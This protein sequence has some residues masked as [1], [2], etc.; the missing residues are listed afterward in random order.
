MS[1]SN[2][3]TIAL[4]VALILVLISAHLCG[5]L[6]VR[7][8]QPR[9]AG[10]IVGGLILGPTLLGLLL[11]STQRAIF[12]DSAATSWMLGAIYQLGLFLLMFCSGAALRSSTRPGERRATA[13]I[14][15]IGNVIPFAA[16]LLFIRLI[17]TGGLI[18]PANNST[19][20]I[21]IFACGLA[22]TSI[23]VI[24]KIMADLGILATSFARIV[25]AVAVIEDVVL[26]VIVSV[27]LGLVAPAHGDSFTLPSLLSIHPSTVLG[28]VYYV[29][30]SIVFFALPLLL[31][32]KFL[33]RIASSRLNVLQRSNPLAF[34]M[35]FVLALTALAL[36][37]GV[38]AYFGAFV[39]GILAGEVGEETAE[40]QNVVRRFS[41]AFF[42]PIYFAIV[43]L[44]LDLIRQFD[45][46][47]FLLFLGYACVVKAVSVYAGS[48][49]AGMTP[50]N[51]RNL[52]VALNARG[53]PAIVLA[54]VAFDARIISQRFTIALVMLALVTSSIAG[55]WL[56]VT[57]RRNAA[58]SASPDDLLTD[59]GAE[60]A[61]EP[62]AA[63]PLAARG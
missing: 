16:G 28:D 30:A 31:G 12:H 39:A 55:S 20:F 14:A 40:A 49:L 35:V 17:D 60:P 43:G 3:D 58:T 8:R 29:V 11:P 33:D 47:F 15:V 36:F 45:I 24:S 38:A 23:P 22:V 59:V 50:S 34:I 6:A 51:S 10:E 4:L 5:D 42:I 13:L 7:L 44:R 62:E 18:G 2:T 25:L 37:L 26:Y 61:P 1:L 19:A 54:S 56:D 48:R 57:L 63:E 46:P 52:A 27:A 32:R 53:G 41:F 9:V 21:L